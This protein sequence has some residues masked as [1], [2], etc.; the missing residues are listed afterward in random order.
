MAGLWSSVDRGVKKDPAV[1]KDDSLLN[2]CPFQLVLCQ[3]MLA[4]VQRAC[5]LGARCEA[6]LFHLVPQ[7]LQKPHAPHLRQQHSVG[8]RCTG[9]GGRKCHSWV[10]DI[11]KQKNTP[12]PHTSEIWA[13]DIGERVL[14]SLSI[15]CDSQIYWLLWYS[16]VLF[17]DASYYFKEMAPH[18]S[19][20]AWRI[21]WTEE[22][23]DLSP[24][25]HK[26][27]DTTETT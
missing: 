8:N 7:H 24:W 12:L 1:L 9:R 6:F 5:N 22:L 21:P 18:S 27:S 25:G 4:P 10:T 3:L 2:W 19:I 16:F 13:W 23:G 26:E 14:H 20:L 15:R 17:K 11:T